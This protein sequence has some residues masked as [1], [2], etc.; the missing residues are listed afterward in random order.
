MSPRVLGPAWGLALCIALAFTAGCAGTVRR[1]QVR[2]AGGSFVGLSVSGEPGELPG[3]RMA[4][5]LQVSTTRSEVIV[6]G[7]GAPVQVDQQLVLDLTLYD[8]RTGRLALSSLRPTHRPLVV[9]NTDDTVFPAL[10]AA[11]V[12][13]RQ[14]SRLV[15]VL[16]SADAYGNGGTPP[17]GVRRTDPVVVVADVLAVPPTAVLASAGGAVRTPPADVPRVELGDSGPARVAFGSAPEPQALRVVPLIDG[18]GPRV[19]D[20]SLVTVDALGQVRGQGS[21]FQ[22]TYFK[23]PSVIPVGTEVPDPAWVRALVGLRQGS[24]VLVLVPSGVGS[25]PSTAW[26]VDVLGV[27]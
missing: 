19:R 9:K 24:R 2:A 16:T 17:V 25:H 21:P 23:E 15:A 20:H 1:D 4:T 6:A 5:P 26:V 18:R 27:S 13:V 11:L 3:I 10:A 14:G 7:T 12:G 8:A 22:D